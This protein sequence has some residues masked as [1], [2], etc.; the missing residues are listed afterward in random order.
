[1]IYK[2]MT[3]SQWDEA[4]AR[5]RFDGSPHDLMDGFIHFSTARQLPGTLAKHYSGQDGLL[6]LELEP[7]GFAP[8]LRW[9]AARDGDLFP[10]HYGVVPLALFGRR[11]TLALDAQGRH[12]LPQD[13]QP[14]PQDGL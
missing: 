5:G 3:S 6:L 11:W 12:C 7:A 4:V 8:P 9:E 1:M 13:L 10:H 14:A 2:I